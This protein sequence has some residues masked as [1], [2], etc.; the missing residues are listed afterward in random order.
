MSGPILGAAR[1]RR[2]S[3]FWE[4]GR[5]DEFFNFPKGRDRSPNLALRE[6]KWKLLL[7]ADGSQVELYDLDEDKFETENLAEEQPET[8]DRLSKELRNWRESLPSLRERIAPAV[9]Q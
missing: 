5:N 1:P 6:G 8:V 3:L 4:Y 2:K 9:L 7:Q